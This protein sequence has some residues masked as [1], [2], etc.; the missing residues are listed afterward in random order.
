MSRRSSWLRPGRAVLASVLVASALTAT[1]VSAAPRGGGN[2][3]E[4]GVDYWLTV[5][6]N[7]DGESDLLPDE[8][9]DSNGDVVGFEKGVAY[10]SR[11]LRDARTAGSTPMYSE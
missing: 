11:A 1:T 6:H 7:N 5:L 9:L 2:N 10:F 8:V 3:S 4:G